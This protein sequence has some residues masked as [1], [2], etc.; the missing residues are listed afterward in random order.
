MKETARIKEL[1]EEIY[2]GDPWL[3]VSLMDTLEKI[4]A[5]TA[6]KKIAPQ[7]N[8]IWEIVNHIIS[9]RENVLLR[10]QGRVITS[11]ADNYFAPVKDFSE[12]AWQETM[13]A[14]KNSQDK[15]TVFLQRMNEG[16]LEKIYTNN[17]ASYYKNIQGIIQHDAYHLGQ[18][19]LLAKNTAG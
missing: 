9:W 17:N 15:W 2:N 16:D 12:K 18:I 4:S 6:A 7:W 10:V 19:I 8:T 3:G 14:L 11:P 5:E 1:F 13:Q